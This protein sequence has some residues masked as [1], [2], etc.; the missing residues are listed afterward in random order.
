MSGDALAARIRSA[1][2]P[3]KVAEK[4]MFGGTCFMLDDHMVAGTWKD[5]LL[6]RVGKE[7]HG[8]CVVRPS[9]RVMEMNGR[10]MQGY[11]IVAS[12]GIAS[13]AALADWLD[14]ACAH[15][16][17]LPPKAKKPAKLVKKRAIKR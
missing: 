5:D 15:V 8:A 1:L 3:R 17:T 13:D 10:K 4:K 6:V 2:A 9:A 16:R 12:E 7:N 14:I 11:V